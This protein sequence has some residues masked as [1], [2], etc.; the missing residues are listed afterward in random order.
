M[1]THILNPLIAWRYYIVYW[2]RQDG[3][4]FYFRGTQRRKLFVSNETDD[5]TSEESHARLFET[6]PEV[7]NHSSFSKT[8]QT[9]LLQSK[10]IHYKGFDGTVL[11][12][13]LIIPE[14]TTK[15]RP[16]G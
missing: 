6:Q 10:E 11:K 13:H 1:L 5:W 7:T 14:K 2:R 12:S 16:P 8:L 4:I 9:T 3:R 15:R